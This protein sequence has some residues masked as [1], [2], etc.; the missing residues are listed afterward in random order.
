M[1]EQLR[2]HVRTTRATVK[3]LHLSTPHNTELAQLKDH[4][5]Q[6]EQE[7]EEFYFMNKYANH[8]ETRHLQH[9]AGTLLDC[10]TSKDTQ[11][12]CANTKEYKEKHG[13]LSI[14]H[15]L[16]EILDGEYNDGPNSSSVSLST[17]ISS[18]SSSS[19]ASSLYNTMSG[20][21]ADE[22]LQQI[23]IVIEKISQKAK[24]QKETIRLFEV[25]CKNA[26]TREEL[27][28]QRER[29]AELVL[30]LEKNRSQRFIVSNEK[31]LT[32]TKLKEQLIKENSLRKSLQSRVAILEQEI[33]GK[34][35]LVDSYDLELKN[36]KD[37]S[38]SDK[39]KI[40]HL[41]KELDTNQGKVDEELLEKLKQE[42]TVWLTMQ[43][44][45]LNQYS[46][47][48]H[49][50]SCKDLEE[51]TTQ[52]VKKCNENEEL[53]N[54]FQ[55]SLKEAQSC[56]QYQQGIIDQ[57]S[58]EKESFLETSEKVINKC[59]AEINDR[60]ELNKTGLEEVVE[61]TIQLL[62]R[63]HTIKASSEEERA[64]E[65]RIKHSKSLLKIKQQ[66]LMQLQERC[67]SAIKIYTT[68]ESAYILQSASTEAELEK[69]LKEYDRLTRNITDFNSERKKF[70]DEVRKLQVEK[71]ELS[72]QLCDKDIINIY[73]NDSVLRK[74]FRDLMATVKEKHKQ[75]LLKEI[76]ARLKIEHL[77][78][79]KMSEKESKR[80]ERVDIAVQ[81]HLQLL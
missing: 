9:L 57:L 71:V 27:M 48:I 5:C 56:M 28:K 25:Q 74:E 67:D 11:L 69:L 70:E 19:A 62:K 61:E 47:V 42:K 29:S 50:E 54:R 21:P 26:D 17:S 35:R 22:I 33:E 75:E 44:R 16:R 52:L 24:L 18:S 73:G 68:R 66:E 81:T 12:V 36:L 77:L 7:L 15:L 30:Q 63:E 38:D 39:H 14:L 51:A 13:F 3:S 46:T 80:W 53:L 20:L 31:E 78:R 43:K 59:V 60:V 76:D 40:R 49:D 23:N 37:Q 8:V 2:V 58:V 79:E 45:I 10:R 55:K 34:E 4:V 1:Y 6:T 41:E 72:R 64:E 65:Y 32:V